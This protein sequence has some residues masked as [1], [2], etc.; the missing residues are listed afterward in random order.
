M[1]SVGEI[2]AV[3][4]LLKPVLKEKFQV[5]TVGIFGSYS[6]GEQKANSDVD[7]LVIFAEP[8]DIDLLD[9]IELKQFLSRKLKTKVDVVQKRAL[10]QRIKDKILQETIYV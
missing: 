1:K 4:V 6:R 8:N 10:K 3:L 7:I 2:K 5:E 9:L